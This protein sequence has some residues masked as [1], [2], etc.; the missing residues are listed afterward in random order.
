MA[1]HA[2]DSPQA[3]PRLIATDHAIWSLQFSPDGTR[4][5]ATLSGGDVV[6]LWNPQSGL[7]VGALR[8]HV[9]R[10]WSCT[11]IEDGKQILTTG[12]D[13]TIRLWDAASLAPLPLHGLIGHENEIW[14]AALAPS[15]NL[16]A[17]GDKDGVL[18]F[19]KWPPDADPAIVLPADRYARAAFS[20]DGNRIFLTI[21]PAAGP[22][23]VRM[24]D[25]RSGI[26]TPL[27]DYYAPLCI[28]PA[29][30][31]IVIDSSFSLLLCYQNSAPRPVHTVRL[32]IPAGS[33]HPDQ[34]NIGITSDG[35]HGFISR[36][37][38]GAT[39]LYD[40]RGE[41]AV[42]HGQLP[43]GDWLASAISPDA[44][45]IAAATWNDLALLDTHTGKTTTLTND[46]HWANAIVFHPDGRRFIT[47]GVDGTLKIWSLPECQ[48]LATLRGH[49]ENASDLA[50]S[51][52]GLTLASIEVGS[53]IRL[54]RLD[55]LREV[56][57]I[58][59]P[60]VLER[61]RFS[62]DGKRLAF[63]VRDKSG[64][65]AVRVLECGVLP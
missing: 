36:R 59:L 65:S 20:P 2:V 22:S 40:L 32:P 28:D 52:D 1:I 29:G 18:R 5:A 63:T 12:S 10:A 58:N 57:A 34:S 62:P 54:W 43:A 42:A 37:E 4:L 15:N 45:W 39:T 27:P 49:L 11:F 38:S 55:T 46:P 44:R 60:G 31:R 17:S 41:S 48:T 13:R 19:W 16:L 25:F 33:L 21:T 23:R 64:K 47:A 30:R 61:I 14:C 24:H 56:V 8:G 53:G 50:L 3:Q 35:S 6:P 7:L 26:D 51:P 9:Q